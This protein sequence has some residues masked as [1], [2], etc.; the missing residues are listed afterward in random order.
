MEKK[1]HLSHKL[2]DLTYS[3]IISTCDFTGLPAIQYEY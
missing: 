3:K 1:L 2:I